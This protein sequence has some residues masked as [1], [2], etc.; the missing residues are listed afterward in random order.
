MRSSGTI[1]NGGLM[2]AHASPLS[3]KSS[4]ETQHCERTSA[5]GFSGGSRINYKNILGWML[6]QKPGFCKIEIL[7]FNIFSSNENI[8]TKYS[9]E[10]SK[11]RI[12]I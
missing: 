10:N 11:M 6:N 9:S 12:T 5:T 2:F 4:P 1:S 8:N 3:A 7:M